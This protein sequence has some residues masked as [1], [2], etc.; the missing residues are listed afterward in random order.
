MFT[1]YK[2]YTNK[3]YNKLVELSRNKFFYSDI[4]LADNFET[5]A[6]LILIFILLLF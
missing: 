4:K 5:R 1:S 6:L 3:L 2:K